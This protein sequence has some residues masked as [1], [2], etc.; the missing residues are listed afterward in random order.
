MYSSQGSIESRIDSLFPSPGF[1]LEIGAWDGELISQTAYL[2][3]D[4]GWTGVCVDPFPVNF[5]NRS[6]RV[7]AR[8]ISRDGLPRAFLKVTID[9][10]YGGNV[11]YFSGFKEIVEHNLHWPV[12]KEFCDYEEIEVQTITFARLAEEYSLPSYIEF[13]SVDVEGSEVE[14]F[15]SIDFNSY[16]FGLIAFEHNMDQCARDKIGEILAANGYRLYEAWEYDD[17]YIFSH[18]HWLDNEYRK[19]IAALGE[20]TVHNFKEHPM[21]KRMLGEIE[22]HEP[23]MEGLDLGTLSL[24]AKIDH[25]GY[26]DVAHPLTISDTAARMVYYARKVLERNPKSIVEIGGGVGQFYAVLRALGYEGEYYIFDLPE[27]QAFQRAYLAEVGKQ[28]GLYLPQK[29]NYDFCVSF[30]ALGEFDDQ[31]KDWYIE[32]V[33][34]KCRHGFVI[35]NPHSGASKEIPFDCKVSPEYPM[36]HPDC[37]QLEW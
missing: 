3:R 34:R 23:V 29:L 28:T 6:C 33:I 24:L 20:S 17:L 21:V 26:L 9:R 2:E 37:K 11:S 25:I 7:C 10:R 30:Y 36:N 5:D 14:I 16:R 35:W 12:I 27:V 22:F 15:E 13:L 18:K 19:W 32:N 4:R 31:L 1:F 8:A